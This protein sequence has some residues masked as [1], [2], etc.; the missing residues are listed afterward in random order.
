MNL[1]SLVRFHEF[2]L[3]SGKIEKR[4]SKSGKLKNFVS[5]FWYNFWDKLMGQFLRQIFGI[6]F[7]AILGQFLGQFL[8]HFLGHFMGQFLVDMS[9]SMNESYFG[10]ILTKNNLY[11]MAR[12]Q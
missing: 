1:S 12:E 3:K 4:S 11:T 5:I 9:K 10:T 6:M 2:F 8:G 7:R